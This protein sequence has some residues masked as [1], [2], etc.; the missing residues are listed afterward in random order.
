MWKVGREEGGGQSWEQSVRG[1]EIG[2]AGGPQLWCVGYIG[3]DTDQTLCKQALGSSQ[4]S[5]KLF[6]SR[7][8]DDDD[9]TKR[10]KVPQEFADTILAPS[11]HQAGS[12]K[13][14]STLTKC[15]RHSR[16]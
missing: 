15:S 4:S 1:Q 8:L 12:G 11:K 7:N 13:D 5:L 14:E 16:R 2:G 9:P 10:A 6:P 3:Q